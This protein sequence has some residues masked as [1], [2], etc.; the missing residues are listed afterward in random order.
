M[1]QTTISDTFDNAN[2]FARPGAGKSELMKYIDSLEPAERAAFFFGRFAQIDD[3]RLVSA[4]FTTDEALEA[5]GQER[6]FSIKETATQGGFKTPRIWQTLNAY[7]ANE[8]A[9]YL[10]LNPNLHNDSTVMAESARGGGATDSMPLPHGYYQLLQQLPREFLDKAVIIYVDV[11]KEQ[12]EAK[13]NARYDPAAPFSIDNHRVPQDVMDEYAVEDLTWM[14]EQAA[15]KGREGFV[16]GP[17]GLWIPTAKFD[18]RTED[19]TTWIREEGCVGTKNAKG[20]RMYDALR[21]VFIPLFERYRQ[22]QM[23]R[24]EERHR[25]QTDLDAVGPSSF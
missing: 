18:N 2:I 15:E 24:M 20:K 14:M 25:Q 17:G 5:D 8:Y 1:A 21:D 16:E 10:Q 12:S 9:K 19:L 4:M 7:I 23:E 6:V 13:N 11:S 3:Y 22:V